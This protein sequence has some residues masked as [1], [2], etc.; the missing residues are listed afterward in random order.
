M[1]SSSVE[2]NHQGKVL[3]AAQ[4]F[5]SQVRR[6]QSWVLPAAVKSISCFKAP[7]WECGYLVWYPVSKL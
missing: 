7:G 3:T 1:C 6:A 5:P 2:Q 4:G